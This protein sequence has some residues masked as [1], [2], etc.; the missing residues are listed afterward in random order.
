MLELYREKKYKIDE[1]YLIEIMKI[2]NIKE[3]EEEKKKKNE[4]VKIKS[5]NR[6][7]K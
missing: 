3:E 4:I 6:I 1:D 7:G 5:Y 2:K